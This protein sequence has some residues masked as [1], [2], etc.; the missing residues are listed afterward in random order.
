[1]AMGSGT[2]VAKEAAQIIITDDNFASIVAGIEEGRYAYANIRKVTWFLISTG[3][4]SL[5]L[6]GG[7]VA[8]ALP[9][10]LSAVQWLWLNLVTNGIQDVA[11]AFEAGEEGAMRQP[12]RDPK[13]G[14][15][16]RRMI[17]HVLLGGIT[18]AVLCFGLWVYLMNSGVEVNSARNILLAFF[19]LIQFFY[20]LTCRSETASAFSISWRRNPVLIG[21]AL[22]ALSVHILS[23]NWSVMQSVLRLEPLSLDKWFGLA[24]LAT[25]VF[26]VME[27]Y[28]RW[29]RMSQE[30]TLTQ[31]TPTTA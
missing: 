17:T 27:T 14:I 10:P 16:D 30:R 7:T 11:L 13:E 19:V 28:K 9:M 3:A 1:V 21:G 22:T 26:I 8:L 18:M 15:F 4:A 23:M 20:V 24:A 2:D 5:I 6:I 29:Q 25:I 31:E 12:P